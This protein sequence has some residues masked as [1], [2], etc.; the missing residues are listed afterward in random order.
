MAINL[1]KVSAEFS[2]KILELRGETVK[3]KKVTPDNIEKIC[4]STL[5]VI[6]EQ[7]LYAGLLFLLSKSGGEE[8]NK[9]EFSVEQFVSC[10][11]V[12]YLVNMLNS[13]GLQEIGCQYNDENLSLLKV[14]RYKLELLEHVNDITEDLKKLLLIKSLF[15]QTLIYTRY[16]A[17]A[18]NVSESK[19][20]M[21]CL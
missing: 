14:N 3:N 20:D 9:E 1:D 18:L 17:K 11:I 15:E 16:G 10:G 2:Q 12:F 13:D 21:E 6:Q 7:G 5:G 8:K 4:T 19:H